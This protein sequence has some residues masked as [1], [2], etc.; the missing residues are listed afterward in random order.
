MATS[1]TGS[2]FF[3]AWQLARRN[4]SLWW[5]AM[6]DWGSVFAQAFLPR[7]SAL[8]GQGP[9]NLLLYCGL[10]VV[11]LSLFV[12]SLVG[13]GGLIGGAFR[14]GTQ[15]RVSVREALDIGG[16][17]YAYLFLIR[18]IVAVPLFLSL[19]LGARDFIALV[20]LWL[21]ASLA[22]FA[23]IA[24]VVDDAQLAEALARAWAVLRQHGRQVIGLSVLIALVAGAFLV[25]ASVIQLALNLGPL[26]EL[27]LWLTLAVSFVL[28]VAAGGLNVWVT[29]AVT[30][31]YVRLTR[32]PVSGFSS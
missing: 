16:R 18:L 23:Q 17:N 6:L 4:P 15:G 20:F 32:A 5:L 31:A 10:G 13:Y 30:L 24:V 28:G 2:T 26:T 21:A 7:L 19:L 27:R 9:L 1:E 12:G 3:D 11:W 25:L 8:G 14:A 22:T 29:S